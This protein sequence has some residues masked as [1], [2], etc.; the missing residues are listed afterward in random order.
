MTGN[1]YINLVDEINNLSL[2]QEFE[3]SVYIFND[4]SNHDRPDFEKNLENINSIK[5][6]I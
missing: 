4:Y 2:N 6:L 1:R 3:I 5:I